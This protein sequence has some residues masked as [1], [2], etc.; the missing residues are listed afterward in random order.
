MTLQSQCK[1][2]VLRMPPG[3]LANL[4]LIAYKLL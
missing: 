3:L 2:P 4:L 1:C